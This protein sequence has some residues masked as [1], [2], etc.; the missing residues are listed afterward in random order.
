MESKNMELLHCPF[1]GCAGEAVVRPEYYVLCC[2]CW[3][4][5][6]GRHASKEEARQAWNKRV[7]N[8]GPLKKRKPSIY[9][10][11]SLAGPEPE[12]E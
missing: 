6:P 5:G 9:L 11:G 8:L 7:I 3:A 12:D 10:N 4:R 2:A 1:C